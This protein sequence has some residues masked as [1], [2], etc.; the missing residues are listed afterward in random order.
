MDGQD[1]NCFHTYLG[2]T[3]LQAACD[4]TSHADSGGQLTLVKILIKAKVLVI[5]DMFY[6]AN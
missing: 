3:A 2:Y 6:F 4:A 1:V 5:C